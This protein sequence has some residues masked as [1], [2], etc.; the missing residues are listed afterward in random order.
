M[1][2][3]SDFKCISIDELVKSRNVDGFEKVRRQGAQILRSEAYFWVRRNDEG[4][5]A[6]QHPDFLR[7]RQ[8]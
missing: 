1:I 4:C 8:H 5:S 3:A 7:S 6:T 2:M